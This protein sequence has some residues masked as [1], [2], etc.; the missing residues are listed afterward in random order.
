MIEFNDDHT[1]VGIAAGDR[2]P[3][4][5]G[6]V[7]TIGIAQEVVP[8]FMVP[9]A[10]P[11]GN[12]FRPI[13]LFTIRTVCVPEGD[14]RGS[15]YRKLQ[16]VMPS[17]EDDRRVYIALDTPESIDRWIKKFQDM[18]ESLTNA[19]TPPPLPDGAGVPADAQGPGGEAGPVGAG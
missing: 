11:S 8:E 9:F 16:D 3:S 14:H 4:S 5:D 17:D 12:Q 2:R 13:G 6:K 7:L 1:Q 10:P 15:E 18:K 19:L